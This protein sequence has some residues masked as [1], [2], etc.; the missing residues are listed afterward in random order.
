MIRKS[1]SLGVLGA[2]AALSAVSAPALAITVECGRLLDVGS[3]RWMEHAMIEVRDGRVVS[4]TTE[5]GGAPATGSASGRE[6]ID[7][8]GYACLPGLI[9][10]HVHLTSAIKPRG[11]GFSDHLFQNPEDAA[12]ESVGFAEKTLLAGFTTVRDLGADKALNVAMKRAV[13]KGWIRGPRI[14][15]SGNGIGSTGGHADGTDALK[16]DFGSDPGPQDGIINSVDDARKAVR[17]RYKEGADVIK[18]VDTGGVLD[19]SSSGDNAQLTEEEIRAVVVTAKDYGFKVAVHAHGAEGINRALRAGVDSI[20]HG[21]YL[22]TESIKLF[23]KTGAYYVP[24]LAAGKFVADKAKLPDYFPDV[25]RPKA[26]AIGP[27]MQG[28]FARAYKAGVNIAFGT[29]SAVSAHGDNAKEFVYMV[30]AGATPLDAIRS[31]TLA[32]ARLLGKQG[33]LGSVEKGKIADLI[34]VEGD[35]LKDVSVLQQ[36]RFVMKGGVVARSP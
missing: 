14:V 18:L 2:L 32:A 4:V 34:A 25:V 36:V 31:A 29:D 19:L 35:P 30:E 13:E 8:S 22:D 1:H 12:Y 9:D 27:L 6:R 3:G 7:L 10:M 21:T 16:R 24:T 23:K 26:A 11:E 33:D 5:A 28:T 17:W 15:A 20:E